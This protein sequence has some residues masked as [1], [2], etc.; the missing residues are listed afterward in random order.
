MIFGKSIYNSIY[1]GSGSTLTLGTGITVRGSNGSLSGTSLIYQGKILADNTGGTVAGYSYDT[2][3][4]GGYAAITA[5]EID[6]SGVAD[7]ASQTVY[8]SSRDNWGSFSYTL[9]NLSPGAGFTLGLD[10]ADQMANAPGQSVFDVTVNGV[11]VLTNF[12][13]YSSAGGSFKAA[14]EEVGVTADSNGKLVVN[15]TPVSDYAQVSGMQVLSG[16]VPVKGVNS[17]VLSGSRLGCTCRAAGPGCLFGLFVC[18][19][20]T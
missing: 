17:E 10:F 3:Y 13:V 20:Q 7:P 8:Q 16:R 5:N 9:G 1:A 15:V 19:T 18:A 14:M 2:G 4:S 12:D 6:T 11:A